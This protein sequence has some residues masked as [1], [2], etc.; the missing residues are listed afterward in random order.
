M[1]EYLRGVTGRDLAREEAFER[2]A[3]PLG[4]DR[5]DWR[6]AWLAS[7]VVKAAGGGSDVTAEDFYRW[8]LHDTEQKRENEQT[9]VEILDEDVEASDRKARE[10][11]QF[12]ESRFPRDKKEE[13]GE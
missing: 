6:V 13:A 12:F 11:Q 1:Q 5:Q 2:V 4:E 7:W 9:E 10:I 3:G 8:F